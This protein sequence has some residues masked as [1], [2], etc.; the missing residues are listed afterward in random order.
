MARFKSRP[1]VSS[2]RQHL[3]QIQTQRIA[4][5]NA[6]LSASD[7]YASAA[8]SH[9]ATVDLIEAVI[10][11]WPTCPQFASLLVDRLMKGDEDLQRALQVELG[12]G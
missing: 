5:T 1:E 2:G 7:R 4:A 10:E 3:Q 6:F 12:D 8:A 9:Q 11:R